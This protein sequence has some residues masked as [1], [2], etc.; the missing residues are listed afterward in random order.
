M[1]LRAYIAG[2]D[3]HAAARVSS[4]IL[5]AVERL[6]ALPRVGRPGTG[7]LVMPRTPYLVAYRIKGSEV[8]ILRVYHGARS[9][10]ARL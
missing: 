4:A 6:A 10:P 9:W 7:E 3:P 1:A 5:T 2:D 8:Q